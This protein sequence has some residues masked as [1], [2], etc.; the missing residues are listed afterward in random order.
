ML[1][2]WKRRIKKSLDES[3]LNSEHESDEASAEKLQET[4]ARERAEEAARLQAAL[5]DAG[6]G[7]TGS[8][9]SKRR[10]V[11]KRRDDVFRVE[12][13]AK[14]Q[15]IKARERAEEAA[16]LQA[17]LNDAGLGT[18]EG[19]KSKRSESPNRRDA[20]RNAIFGDEIVPQ[21]DTANSD[22]SCQKDI[23]DQSLGLNLGSGEQKGSNDRGQS[24]PLQS[25]RKFDTKNVASDHPVG[26]KTIH[27]EKPGESFNVLIMKAISEQPNQ[28]A[29]LGDIYDYLMRKYPYYNESNKK[30]WQNSVRHN[31]SVNRC[32]MRIARDPN[33]HGK[34][35]YWVLTTH[36]DSAYVKDGRLRVQNHHEFAANHNLSITPNVWP[37]F[38]VCSS[39][40][41]SQD[42]MV[43]QRHPLSGLL[44]NPFHNFPVPH[45]NRLPLHPNIGDFWGTEHHVSNPYISPMYA[46]RPLKSPRSDLT[47]ASIG[48]AQAETVAQAAQPR[49]FN[50]IRI[51]VTVQNTTQLNDS[52]FYATRLPE[53]HPTRPFS[54]NSNP[55][56]KSPHMAHSREVKVLFSDRTSARSPTANTITRSSESFTTDSVLSRPR[57]RGIMGHLMPSV[58]VPN[59]TDISNMGQSAAAL[60]SLNGHI[61]AQFI[62]TPPARG[63]SPGAGQTD[64]FFSMSRPRGIL[65]PFIFSEIRPNLTDTQ[66]LGQSAADF[67]NYNRQIRAQ[68]FQTPTSSTT[69]MEVHHESVHDRS[70]PLQSNV[71]DREE[72]SRALLLYES[73]SPMSGASVMAQRHHTSNSRISGSGGTCTSMH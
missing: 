33:E 56:T 46:P 63:P 15:E 64:S 42:V 39:T 23:K 11:P 4:N 71:L 55:G 16:R 73:S 51:P 47:S 50:P 52:P 6:L 14:L 29:T 45:A 20:S 44:E 7:T 26:E 12:W 18:T 54:Q 36:A 72:R 58:T 66:S 35:C 28:R 5:N 10:E 2:K 59:V 37:S 49:W 32:F 48:Y 53:Q 38:P 27:F 24:F 19:W 68:F 13:A 65:N 17:A 61:S 41:S 62:Q 40:P 21:K 43:S 69:P 3:L 34:G 25:S 31:L 8:W 30:S 22:N 57:D 1:Q 9:K 60:S 70:S 67:A